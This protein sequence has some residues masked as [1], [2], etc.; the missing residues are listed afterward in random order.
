MSELTTQG[1]ILCAIKGGGSGG[2]TEDDKPRQGA[3]GAR[4]GKQKGIGV[5][6]RKAGGRRS[7][8]HRRVE[9]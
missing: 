6:S 8:G 1:V 9:S 4:M 5:M 2:M 3:M 7:H